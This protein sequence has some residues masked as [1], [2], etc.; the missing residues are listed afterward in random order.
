MYRIQRHVRMILLCASVA[1]HLLVKLPAI[2]QAEEAPGLVSKQFLFDPAPHPQCHASTIVE[3]P[4]GLIAAWFG[5]TK[6]GNPDVGIWMSRQ[7]D[8]VWQPPVEIANGSETENPRTH[9]SNPVLFQMPGGPLLLFYKTGQWWPY[10]KKS[11]DHGVT[12]SQPERMPNGFFGP[13][14]NKP[15]L[16]SDGSLLCPSSTEIGTPNGSAWQLQFERTVNGGKSW[17]RIGPINEGREI[18][19]IQPSLLVHPNKRLQAIGRTR[20]SRLFEVWSEDEGRTW[21]PVTL[22]DLPNPNSGT[23]AVTLKDGRHLLVYNHSNNDPN[24]DKPKGIRSPLNVAISRDGK[25]WEAALVLENEPQNQFSYPAV[26]QAE[27]GLV[28]ITYTWKRLRISH[29]V[30]DPSQLVTKPIVGGRWPDR[31]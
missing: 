16:L 21:S 4:S 6:E 10:I 15:I 14:K 9:C 5:G 3:T 11:V 30:I 25:N 27:D 13:I 23:D 29:A 26:I 31:Q 2:A 24:S 18:H 12:W 8:K 22:M 7:I 17:Q 28:H 19:T 1:A 20:E